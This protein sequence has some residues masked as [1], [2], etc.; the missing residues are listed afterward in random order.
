MFGE[1]MLVRRE[2]RKLKLDVNMARAMALALLPSN[3]NRTLLAQPYGASII[4]HHRLGLKTFR[5]SDNFC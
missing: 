1:K 2:S 5:T 4:R 3:G